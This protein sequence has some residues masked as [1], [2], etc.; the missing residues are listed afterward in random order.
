L[1]SALLVAE[2]IAIPLDRQPR[3]A[4]GAPLFLKANDEITE[5]EALLFHDDLT[6]AIGRVRWLIAVLQR[7]EEIGPAICR[8]EVAS[9]AV[10]QR[11]TGF[12]IAQDTLLTNWHVLHFK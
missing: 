8:L 11:G 9:P 12:R 2:P 6:L 7:I 4:D 10:R 1:L 5:P 3:D